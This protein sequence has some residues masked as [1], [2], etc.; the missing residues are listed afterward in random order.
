MH[1]DGGEGEVFAEVCRRGAAAIL[2]LLGAAQATDADAQAGR[3]PG[4][5]PP[6]IEDVLEG[7]PQGHGNFSISYL[8]HLVNGFRGPDGNISPNAAIRSHAIALSVDY[9]ITDRWT[10][11][12]E[13]PYIVNRYQGPNPHCPTAAPPQ[14]ANMP[15]LATPHPESQFLDDGSYHGAWQD[16]TLGAAYNA[17]F[18]GY[19]VTP[20]VT[21]YLPSHDYTF[22]SQA[23]V[24][25]G[26]QRVE[27][28]ATLAHQFDFTQV[29]Y[30]VG[31]GRVFAEE[32]LGQSIDHNKVDLELGYFLNPAWTVKLFSTAKKGNGY[33]GGYDRTTELWYHHDQR[34]PHNYASVGFGVDYNF[35]KYTLSSS[36]QKEIWGQ[37]IFNFQYAFELRLTRSF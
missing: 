9:N 10:L 26:L 5:G 29:Y 35:N 14:C 12:A 31:Y 15:A 33:F 37:V 30:R 8:N 24:G 7:S 16:W 27:L 36:V 19:F 32:T 20:Y 25:Y 21:V 17:D 3:R 23:A 11:H 28:G 4:E 1:N 22:F 2:V 13:I 18:E 6:P 34:A